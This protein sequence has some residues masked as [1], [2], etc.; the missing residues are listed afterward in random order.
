MQEDFIMAKQKAY[1]L[2]GIFIITYWDK[3]RRIFDKGNLVYYTGNILRRYVLLF[4]LCKSI[5][6]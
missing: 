1:G 4:D 6:S 3:S 2:L 5:N